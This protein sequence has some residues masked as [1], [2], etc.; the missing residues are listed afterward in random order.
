[1][2]STRRSLIR[3]GTALVAAGHAG[4]FQTFR[5]ESCT[6]PRRS[7]TAD[8][9]RPRPWFSTHSALSWI[10]AMASRREAERILRPMGYDLDWLAFADAWRKEYGPGMGGSAQRAAGVRQSWIFCIAKILIASVRGSSWRSSRSRRL[11]SLTSP[12]TNSTPGPMSVQ[13]LRRLHKRFLMAT[14][15]RNGNIAL[16]ADVGAAQQSPL[17]RNPRFRDRPGVQT[18]AEGLPSQTCEAFNLK[19]EQVMMCAAHSGGLV[20]RPEN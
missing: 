6:G 17:G 9:R 18:A 2:Y 1:M 8:A 16:M 11:R 14:L 20:V 12:G 10:G 5:A 4:R 13:P 15:P 3:R 7:G 19:P